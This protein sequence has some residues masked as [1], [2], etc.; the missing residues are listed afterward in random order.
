MQTSNK[1]V[2]I[3]FRPFVGV[4][5]FGGQKPYRIPKPRLI[6]DFVEGLVG[7]NG[8]RYQVEER[9]PV[10]DDDGNIRFYRPEKELVEKLN[11]RVL[12]GRIFVDWVNGR[13]IADGALKW[14]NI[15]LAQAYSIPKKPRTKRVKKV[16]GEKVLERVATGEKW[17][18][19]YIN[20]DRENPVSYKDN[21]SYKCAY[22]GKIWGYQN[23]AESCSLGHEAKG[24]IE[25]DAYAQGIAS[26][27][28]LEID[29]QVGEAPTSMMVVLP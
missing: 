6:E 22:C 19:Q 15:T 14:Y 7:R 13:V 2:V 11:Y 26:I 1:N 3:E 8:G 17:E 20:G 18:F 23:K 24:L 10:Y 27:V 28:P 25:G 12:D 9:I 4:R 21:Y 16:E 5:P 29:I